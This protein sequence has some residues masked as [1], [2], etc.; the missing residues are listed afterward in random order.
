[1]LGRKA[2]N[3]A[4]TWLTIDKVALFCA[5]SKYLGGG[6]AGIVTGFAWPAQLLHTSTPL[7]YRHTKYFL[8]HE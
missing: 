6:A 1:L 2:S 8:G 5:A 7:V 4:F 3:Q